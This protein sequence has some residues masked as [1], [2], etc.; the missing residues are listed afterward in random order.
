MQ[1]R[2]NYKHSGYLLQGG[3]VVRGAKLVICWSQVQAFH[4]ATHLIFSR[5]PYIQ[6]YACTLY[7]VTGLLRR[8]EF[9]KILYL[10]TMFV[11]NRLVLVL[12]GPFGGVAN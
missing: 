3:Q 12:G 9:F 6:L 4:P 5:L 1:G 8:V 7:I 2:Q 10:F 11:S